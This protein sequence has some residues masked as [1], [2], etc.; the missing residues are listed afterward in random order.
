MPIS[1]N[2][3]LKG[4]IA[5][6]GTLAGGLDERQ[7]LNGN[8]VRRGLDGISP[9]V[10]VADI[11]GGHRIT[12]TDIYGTKTVDVLDGEKGDPGYTPQKGIDYF[13][14]DKGDK[15][16]PGYTPI[17]GVD[18]F[19]G[20][21]G[22]DGYSPVKGVDYFD[23]VDGKDGKTPVKGVDYFD[24]KDGAQGK[25]GYTPVKGKDYFD[26]KDG[27]QGKDGTDGYSPTVSVA[28]IDGGHRVTITDKDGEK[29]FDVLDGVNGFEPLVVT[30]VK[31]NKASHSAS[32]IVQARS[33]GRFV[34]FE[35]G[36]VLDDMEASGDSVIF[37][38]M[39][40]YGTTPMVLYARI[41]EEKTV[42]PYHSYLN[43]E[44]VGAQPAFEAGN[45]L[46]LENGV[47]SVNTTN[48][49]EQDNTLPITAAGVYTAVGNIE[50]LLKTI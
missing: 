12:I 45:G 50:A 16:D 26:G 32:E 41:D 39:L 10:S 47:L 29:A 20:K 23:G 34:L 27:S 21:D 18:Y 19:D 8:V 30:I 33:E 25:D 6:R 37:S 13:D 36:F 42:T 28:D 7:G 38:K 1:Q 31:E 49:M 48:D 24:G 22:K 40:M 14:G 15:G 9:V 35:N 2:E 43:A 44:A 4:S 5:Q 11:E 3:T 17:K 46:T